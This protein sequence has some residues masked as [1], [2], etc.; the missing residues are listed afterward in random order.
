M[1]HKKPFRIIITSII[2]VC[3]MI[4]IIPR[5]KTIIELSIQKHELEKQKIKLVEKNELLVEQLEKSQS[6][7]NMERIAR[8]QLGMVK[9]GEQ[10]ITPIIPNHNRE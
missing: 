8:E 6:L 10:K 1:I 2:F 5:V 9:K 7:E 4:T 3:L